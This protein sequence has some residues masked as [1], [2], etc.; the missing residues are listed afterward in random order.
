MQDEIGDLVVF[1]FF[2]KKLGAKFFHTL[3]CL[4]QI[5]K[6]QIIHSHSMDYTGLIIWLA[7]RH[8]T[9]PILQG[10][11]FGPEFVFNYSRLTV[12]F[13]SCLCHDPLSNTKGLFFK[14]WYGFLVLT[15]FSVSWSVTL[16]CQH[17]LFNTPP[18]CCHSILIWTWLLRLL[19]SLCGATNVLSNV[20]AFA[21]RLICEFNTCLFVLAA[22]RFRFFWQRS[23]LISEWRASGL[24]LGSK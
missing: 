18:L 19:R 20:E 8:L 12:T 4:S 3:C 23:R 10:L 6:F 9:H 16:S 17:C 11:F 24:E 13:I 1:I 22:L 21:W 5:K 14:T 15:V 7:F 2:V